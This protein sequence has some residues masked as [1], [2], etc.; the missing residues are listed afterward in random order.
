[1]PPGRT[2]SVSLQMFRFV[3]FLFVCTIIPSLILGQEKQYTDTTDVNQI[4]GR[5]LKSKPKPDNKKSGLALL[6]ALGYNPSM[7]FIIGANISASLYAGDPKTT[8]LST[9][10]A[11]VQFTTKGIINFQ[12]RHNIFT[13]GD[14]WIFQGNFQ[15]SRMLVFD[16]GLGTGPN[17]GS[18]EGLIVDGNPTNDPTNTFP[19]VFGLFRLNEKVYRQVSPSL[20]IGGGINF[21]FHNNIRDEKLQ[22]DSGRLTPHYIYSIENGINPEQYF[23]NGL[24]FNIQYNTKEHGNRSY[25]GMYADIVLRA[26]QKFL[27]STLNSLQL[28]TEFK[29]YWSLSTR[30]P[31]NVI[32]IWHIGTFNLAGTVPYL[33]LPATGL[34]LYNRSGRGYTIGRFRGPSYFYLESEYR[35]PISRNKLFSGVAF[36]NLQTASDG[37]NINL[38]DQLEPAAGGGLRILF[39]KRSR[40]NICIDYAV[41]IKGS[42]GFFFGL[43]EVF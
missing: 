8:R 13:N 10:I 30:N 17:A 11:T 18:D 21:D 40:T 23:A 1:M 38:F 5:I 36:V 24:T 35:F 33:D 26:N 39:N 37:K 25:G 2:F 6:P 43:N 12:L 29:K 27:G 4:I 31:E 22:V 42:N 15:A 32:A 7:G 28:I 9:G 3:N 41:G 34:D 16:Y 14:D 19:I 20:F